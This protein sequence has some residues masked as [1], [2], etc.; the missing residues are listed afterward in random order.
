MI[1]FSN[2]G[3]VVSVLDMPGLPASLSVRLENFG[4]F[5]TMRSI[6]TSV[7]ISSR[8]NFQFLHTI[9]GSVHVS[10][11]GDRIG[12]MA[13]AGLA[14]DKD[15]V[16]PGGLTGIERVADYYNRNRIAG[17]Q[18]PLRI[19]IGAGLSLSAMLVGLDT[20]VANV[21][22]RLHEFTLHM[23]L[24]PRPASVPRSRSKSSG[25]AAATT[26]STTTA[27]TPVSLAAYAD[28]EQSLDA[29]GA[30]LDGSPMPNNVAGAAVYGSGPNNL[31]TRG[32]VLAG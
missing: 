17:R 1:M 24:I 14:F 20:N 2:T 6:V 18:S 28:A 27:A 21:E 8:G 31:L 7:R 22:S 11:F 16:S 29:G 3:G 26:S 4:G 10:V 15:C 5:A 12:Q 23:A 30:Y 9:G 13:V 25:G 32:F 19:T